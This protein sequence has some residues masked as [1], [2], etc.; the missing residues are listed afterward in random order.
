MRAQCH[1]PGDTAPSSGHSAQPRC[2][3]LAEG[4]DSR[5]L[6]TT[7][8]CL[9]SSRVTPDAAPRP[10]SLA[11]IVRGA[12][13]PSETRTALPV[14]AAGPSSI[15]A[16]FALAEMTRTNM[17]SMVFIR[18]RKKP[19]SVHLCRNESVPDEP[20]SRPGQR[21]ATLDLRLWLRCI[22]AQG[23]WGP[24]GAEPTEGRILFY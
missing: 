2:E 8:V 23:S 10:A 13:T 18:E 14:N 4:L 6:T 7:R 24:T 9:A 19:A 3:A 17:Y 20:A 22:L 12:V 16:I 15:T 5:G 1:H 11:L 21:S